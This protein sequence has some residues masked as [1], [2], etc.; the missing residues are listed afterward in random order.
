MTDPPNDAQ[1]APWLLA[2]V[3]ENCYIPLRVLDVDMTEV[4]GQDRQEAFRILVRPIPRYQRV[5]CESVPHVMQTCDR[6]DR[7]C[8]S[9]RSVG[10]THKRF[11]GCLRRP[12]DCPGWKRTNKPAFPMAFAPR[13]VVG[14]NRAGRCV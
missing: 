7:R 9:D 14:K 3:P 1:A 13:V 2:S 6:D 12:D 8:R 11:D 4:G 5:R 10:T